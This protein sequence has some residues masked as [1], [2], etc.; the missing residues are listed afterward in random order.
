MLVS[1]ARRPVAAAAAAAGTK[2]KEKCEG[3]TDDSGRDSIVYR[4]A[5]S[6]AVGACRIALTER[7]ARLIAR[8][9]PA[10]GGR[11]CKRQLG[12]RGAT[13]RKAGAAIASGALTATEMRALGG[14]MIEDGFQARQNH[15]PALE[16][17]HISTQP[18]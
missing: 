3:S 11:L 10:A 1:F 16:W 9:I 7:R 5:S 17:W 18:L 12:N 8:L 2:C 14:A 15:K 6:H 4:S 13:E